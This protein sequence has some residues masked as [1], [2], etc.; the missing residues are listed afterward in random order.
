MV[1]RTG[2]KKVA[3][4]IATQTAC[5]PKSDMA[6]TV[7]LGGSVL[8]THQ[9]QTCGTLPAV[10]E[11]LQSAVQGDFTVT[12]L[13]Q[14]TEGLKTNVTQVRVSLA[15]GADPTTFSVPKEGETNWTAA[16]GGYTFACERL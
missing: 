8:Q 6:V 14:R 3:T 1:L 2:T 16:S 9:G 4:E 10:P 11:A 5:S 12:V 15:G 13:G 7:P